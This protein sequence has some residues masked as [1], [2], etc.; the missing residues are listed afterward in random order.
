[1]SKLDFSLFPLSRRLFYATLLSLAL[2]YPGHNALQSIILHPGPIK[3]YVL[4]DYALAPYPVNDGTAIPILYSRSVVVQDVNS[5]VIMYSHYPDRI[6]LPAST[7]KIMT[8]LVALD[9]YSLDQVLTIKTEDRAVGSTM[10][11]VRGEQISIENLL[12]GLLVHSGNDAALALAENVAGG[13]DG[14]VRRMNDKAQELHLDSTV[15]KHP[16]GV[17]SYGHVT[18][19][20]DLAVL[21]AVAVQ[22]PVINKIMQTKKI[23]VT[24]LTGTIPHVLE[25]TNDLL[26]VLDG[27]KGLKTGWTENAGECL[28]TYVE[29][30][31]HPIITVVLGS[32]DRFG[33]TTRLIDWVYAHHHWIDIKDN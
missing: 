2:F 32:S 30:D 3:S 5:K 15:Y 4:G 7:T 21:A 28:V 33:D 8:A 14:F 17:E 11:L 29:R 22:N 10:E 31:G 12:Y 20:R 19:A 27:V 13:Y 9:N 6:L 16:S 18:S 25:T 1:M 26:G 24:D 23:T